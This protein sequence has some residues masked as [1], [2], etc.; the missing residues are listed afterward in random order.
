[1]SAQFA[2]TQ[3]LDEVLSY[4]LVKKM[5]TRIDK[6]KAYK[7]GLV[8]DKGRTLKIAKTEEEKSALGLLDKFIFKLKRIIGPRINELSNFLYVNSFESDIE[9]YLTVK[10]GV[11]N[12]AAI[13]RV[14]NDLNQL[15]EKY[16]MDISEMLLCLIHE[17]TKK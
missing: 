4:I 16:N 3:H 10:G 11:Q 9:K 15:T 14:T 12:K 2:N 5:L 7:L 1:M 8:D 13:K 6:T 17:E